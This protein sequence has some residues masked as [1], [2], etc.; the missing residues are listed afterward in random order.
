MSKNIAHVYAA[1]ESERETGRE[2]VKC[3]R[4]LADAFES[5]TESL[6]D[7]LAEDARAYETAGT[8]NATVASVGVNVSRDHYRILLAED[9]M[10]VATE[11]HRAAERL[12]YCA[13]SILP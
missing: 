1:I 13:F 10:K 9:A 7:G 3:L 6:A 11:E 5:Y 2:Y 8:E 12:R 4:A